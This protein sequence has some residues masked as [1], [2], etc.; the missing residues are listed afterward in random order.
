MTD[1][2]RQDLARYRQQISL[3]DQQLEVAGQLIDGVRQIE[4][5]LAKAKLVR[6]ALPEMVMAGKGKGKK[7]AIRR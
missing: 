4:E 2:R 5:G 1:E 7:V 3:K 6:E